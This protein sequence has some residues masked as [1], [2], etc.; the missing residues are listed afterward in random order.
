VTLSVDGRP[1]GGA[2]AAPLDIGYDLSDSQ[3]FFLGDYAGGCS[4]PLG[5]VGDIDA[6]ALVG[7]YDPEVALGQ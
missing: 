6:A 7:H 2:V 1:V 3:D 5:F 4:S